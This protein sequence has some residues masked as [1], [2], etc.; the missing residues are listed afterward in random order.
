MTAPTPATERENRHQRLSHP[1]SAPSG[2][3]SPRWA[4]PTARDRAS[5]VP[6]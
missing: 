2:P 1:T 3:A 6:Q 4:V 5:G